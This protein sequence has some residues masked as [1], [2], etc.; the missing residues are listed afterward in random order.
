MAATKAT[1]W[2]G[3]VNWYPVSNLKIALA[4][5]QTAFDGGAASGDRE[6]EKLILTRF[7]VAF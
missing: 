1:T 2:A 3:G 4:Y 6:D 5:S 7:Q